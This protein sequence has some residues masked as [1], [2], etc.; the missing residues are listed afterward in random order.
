MTI[1]YFKA[2][3]G[4]QKNDLAERTLMHIN[5]EF[6]ARVEPFTLHLPQPELLAGVWMIC[7]ESLL[8]GSV[9]RDLKEAVATTVSVINRCPY[10][11]DAHGIMILGASGK[12]YAEAITAGTY[13]AIDDKD[14]RKAV[15]WAAATLLPGSSI[16]ADPPFSPDEAPEYIGTA[17]CFHYINRMV[18]ILLGPTPLPF[19]KGALK[20]V[21]MRLASWFFGRSIRV[22]KEPCASLELLPR[23]TLPGDLGWASASACIAHAYAAFSGT[24]ERAGEKVLTEQVRESISKVVKAWNGKDPGMGRAWIEESLGA[25]TGGQRAAGELA[26]LAA[27]APYLVTP[28]EVSSFSAYYPGDRELLAVLA[29]GSFTAARRAGGWMS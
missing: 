17:V 26:L 6:G 24:V 13:D 29:W 19:G 9:R 3:G 28:A 12:S 10:C 4:G 23:A 25:C 8:V 18:T 27:L 7:R 16:L 22:Y 15:E 2:A 1:R 5:S 21:S 14:V 20:R 11:V